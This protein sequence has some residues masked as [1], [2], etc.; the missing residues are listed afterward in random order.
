MDTNIVTGLAQ[1]EE[2]TWFLVAEA[3]E[4]KGEAKKENAPESAALEASVACATSLP[5]TKYITEAPACQVSAIPVFD[6]A[7][8]N[9]TLEEIEVVIADAARKRIESAHRDVEDTRDRIERECTAREKTL[10]A[11]Q[12][13][14]SQIQ[15]A[16]DGL[17]GER[18]AM[19]SRAR[20]FLGGDELNATLGQIHLAFNARQLEL[21]DALATARTDEVDAQ[22][23]IQAADVSDALEQQ[24]AEQELERLESAAPEVAQALQQ[25]AA[26]SQI[27]ASAQQAIQDGMLRDAAAL[28]EQA[29]KANADAFGSTFV[30][31]YTERSRSA[32]G[33]AEDQSAAIGK[34]ERALANA[35][36]AQ[37]AR[38]LVARLN[39]AC[40]LP[41]AFKRIKQIQ[42][43]ASAAGVADKVASAVARAEQVARR[44]ANE[45]FAQARPIADHL[46]A[47]GYV[48]V[49]GDGRI[50]AWKLA[51][52]S[53]S[54][55]SNG[56]DSSW[57]LDRILVLRANGVWATE[58]PRVSIT[59]KSLA[60]YVK[61]SRWYRT[62]ASNRKTGAERN[63]ASDPAS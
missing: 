43:E 8:N 11:M 6:L 46:V 17:A 38:D 50:E 10:Q 48:P 42:D 49:V 1:A 36:K 19:D 7:P 12:E 29:K 34:L 4:G 9:I 39:T 40:E 3:T 13:R 61:H 63:A 21:E 16:L 53:S 28:I 22:A 27:I 2:T 52:R 35:Q 18:A 32:Q 20:A 59:R 56:N 60:P 57:V 41:G 47:E 25:A 62:W 30:G 5:T 55:V 37:L 31:V 33:T 44:A 45:R 58:K 51:S 54:A 24:L 23:E 26:V 14:V 15:A